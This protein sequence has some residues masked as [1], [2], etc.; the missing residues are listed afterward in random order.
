MWE[1]EFTEELENLFRQYEAE[2]YGVPPDGYEE[3]CY[4]AMTYDEFVGYIKEA[5]RRHCEL[6][7][8]VDELEGY[9]EEE[10]A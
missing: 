5:L 7:E 6:V 3:L 8:V 9:S 2:N 1:G 10:E 4:T